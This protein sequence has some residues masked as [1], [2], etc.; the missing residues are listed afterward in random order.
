MLRC[1]ISFRAK[2]PPLVLL[3]EM[4][5]CLESWG[6]VVPLLT[7]R[8]VL[9]YDQRGAGLSQKIMGALSIE[10]SVADL[11]GLLDA[12]GIGQPVALAGCAVGA[13]VALAFAARH[14]ARVS[15]VVAMAPATGL[16]VEKRPGILTLAERMEREGVRARL[17]ERFDETFLA[18]YRTDPARYAAFRG[19]ALANDPHS[20]AATYRM[21]AGMDLTSDLPRIACPCLILAGETD[22]TRPAAIV[23]PV[24]D[25]IPGSRF[26]VVPSGHVMPMLTPELVARTLLAFP[27]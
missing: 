19:I 8:T 27:D 6:S 21:L 4:G 9:R 22:A 20:F 16:A 1:I 23:R 26:A 14:P 13:G 15:S 25:A 3:H 24:A 10:D 12:L 5:G 17:L 7:G 2:D 18:Q 11:A